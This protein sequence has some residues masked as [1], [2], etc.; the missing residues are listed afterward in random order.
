VKPDLFENGF[1]PRQAVFL[2]KDSVNGAPFNNWIISLWEHK[3][4]NVGKSRKGIWWMP[5]LKKTMKDVAACEKP[6]RGGKQPLTRGSPNGVTFPVVD[7]EP[8]SRIN[9]LM[10]GLPG[11]LKHLSSRRKRKKPSCLTNVRHTIFNDQWSI[12]NQYSISNIKILNR[13]FENCIMENWKFHRG[14]R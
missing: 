3:K 12:F 14:E 11:E 4:R 13:G 1:K 10:R 7:G 9:K 5:W 8:V 2:L 6:R